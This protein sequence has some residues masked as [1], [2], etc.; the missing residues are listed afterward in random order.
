MRAARLLGLPAALIATLVLAASASA[1]SVQVTT[2]LDNSV[3]DCTLRD[4][5]STVSSGTGFGGCPDPVIAPGADVV[6]FA[7]SVSGQTI[8]LT[9][10]LVINDNNPAGLDIVG[11]GMHQLTLDGQSNGRVLLLNVGR[12]ASISGLSMIN[13]NLAGTV[14]VGGGIRTAGDLTLTDVRV[15]NNAVTATAAGDAVAGGAGIDSAGGS[16]TLDHSVVEDN[17][18]SATNTAGDGTQANAFGAGIFSGAPLTIEDSVIRGNHATAIDG[19]G[20]QADAAG[21]LESSGLDASHST[22]SGNTATSVQ[23]GTGAARAVGGVMSSGGGNLDLN[24]VT[25]NF[26]DPAGTAVIIPAGG[27]DVVAGSL[28]IRSSTIARNGPS[29]LSLNGANLITEGGTAT[30]TNTLVSDPRGNGTNQNCAIFSGAIAS[31]GFND[32]YSPA[33]ASCFLSSSHATDLTTNPLLAVALANNG[34]PTETLALQPTSPAIDAGLSTGDADP[35]HDQRGLTRPVEFSGIANAAGGNG[36]DIGAF[37]I[38]STCAGQATPGGTCPSGG[39]G[40]NPAPPGPTGRRGAAL[41]KC[42]KKKGKKRK[43][44][45]KRAKKLPV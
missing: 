14:P 24:T 44:C 12:T 17:T 27:V 28:A 11:P 32:D 35:T 45:I 25:G 41:K 3:A 9:G 42:K 38:Q 10:Q 6:T 20:G 30:L 15:A 29:S 1:D 16:L 13:G 39:G 34:G 23:T 19:G 31:G 2:N 18:A 43:K 21:G 40:A 36:A 33:G 7:P 5:I 26:A 8:P 22:F 37:E 4:A